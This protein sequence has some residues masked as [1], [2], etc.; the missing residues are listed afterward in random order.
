MNNLL[1]MTRE[2]LEDYFIKIGEKKY[3]AL[4]VYEW[5]YQKREFNI[6]NFSNIKKEIRDKLEQDFT[7]DFITIEK[8]ESEDLTKKYLFKLTDNNYA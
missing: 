3:K 8:K 7:T 6:A 2:E 4:Q 1:N 5:L